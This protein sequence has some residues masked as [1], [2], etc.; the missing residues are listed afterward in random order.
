M[1]AGELV[2]E[3]DIHKVLQSAMGRQSDH[4]KQARAIKLV[5]VLARFINE[6]FEIED[7]NGGEPL[8][9][10]LHS[11][12]DARRRQKRYHFQRATVTKTI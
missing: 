2:T 4:S 9:A 6:E 1:T 11:E 5:S 8:K 12:Q 10:V 3:C 7:P